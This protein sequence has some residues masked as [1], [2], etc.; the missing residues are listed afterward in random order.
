MAPALRRQLQV[1]IAQILV[2]HR[3]VRNRANG[4]LQ[5]IAGAF[6]VALGRPDHGQVVVGLGQLGKLLDQPVELV[7]GIG[8]PLELKERQPFQEAQPGIT[9]RLL[10][11]RIGHGQRPGRI[12]PVQGRLRLP[13]L[14]LQLG[15][16]IGGLASAID[17]QGIG[18]ARIRTVIACTAC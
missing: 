11:G 9:R 6:Q 3:V 8:H 2:G 18:Q 4:S 16:G 13:A 7:L 12:A 14:V 1:Q 17:R 10:Q 5:G 15:T